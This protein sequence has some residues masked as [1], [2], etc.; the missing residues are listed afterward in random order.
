M[1][2]A[3]LLIICACIVAELIK[4]EILYRQFNKRN[5]REDEK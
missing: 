5:R 4:I 3:L 2:K 1:I